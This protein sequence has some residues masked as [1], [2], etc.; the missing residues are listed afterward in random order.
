MLGRRSI[1]A[2]GTSTWIGTEKLTNSSLQTERLM[3]FQSRVR[4][5][6]DFGK[7]PAKSKQKS[8][9]S[10]RRSTSG[11]GLVEELPLNAKEIAD[12]TV[13]MLR[14]LGSQRFAVPPFHEHFD[15][16]LLSLRD[17][18]SEFESGGTFD[19][20]DQFRKESAD[21]V[22]QVKRDLD[23]RRLVEIAV[24]E[25]ARFIN[26][27][28]LEKKSALARVEREKVSRTKEMARQEETAVK[29][30]VTRI[31]RLKNELNQF[32]HVRAGLFRSISKKAKARRQ[33]EATQRLE[34]TRK[35]L[36]QAQRSLAVEQKRLKEEYEGRRRQL[37]E[38]IDEYDKKLATLEAESGIDDAV[39]IRR[40][41]CEKLEKALNTFL[42]R[43]RL[44]RSESHAE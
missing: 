32:S 4:T 9:P 38:Q 42:E 35:Q 25:K 26:Q 13:N 44:P 31:G 7:R 27:N 39:E 21:E 15:R 23:D 11:H 3:S 5:P 6:R 29:P 36:K 14:H 24:A 20:D 37:L 10:R 18:L 22:S 34:S 28:L 19:V 33:E 17:I 2:A 40:T 43:N 1:L 16:W 8:K 12:R 41:T 30:V